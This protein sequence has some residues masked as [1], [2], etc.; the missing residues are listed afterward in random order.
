[1]EV[2]KN[3]KPVSKVVLSVLAVFIIA[4]GMGGYGYFTGFFDSNAPISSQKTESPPRLSVGSQTLV[5][6]VGAAANA[7]YKFTDA[8]VTAFNAL[9]ISTEN[10]SNMKSGF[11]YFY[12]PTQISVKEIIGSIKPVVGKRLLFIQYSP[13]D[14]KFHIYPQ[15]IFDMSQVAVIADYNTFKVDPYVPF[16]IMTDTATQYWNEALK[17]PSDSVNSTTAATALNARFTALN[18]ANGWTMVALDTSKKGSEFFV[19]IKNRIRLMSLMKP[20]A[21]FNGDDFDASTYEIAGKSFTGLYSIAWVK[22][23]PPPTTTECATTFEYGVCKVCSSTTQYMETKTDTC[24]DCPA[25]S[26]ADSSGTSCVCST[27]FEPGTGST[28]V[29]VAGVCGTN[30]SQDQYLATDTSWLATGTF[31]LKGT[32]EPAAPVFP[33]A[34]GSVTWKCLGSDSTVAT[35]DI[36]CTA[37]RAAVAVAG[38]CGT[39]NHADGLVSKPTGT[40]A[41]ATGTVNPNPA[42]NED[43]TSTYNWGCTGSGTEAT[44]TLCAGCG[45]GNH[46]DATLSKCTADAVAFKCDATTLDITHATSCASYPNPNATKTISL[47][48]DCNG[49]EQDPCVYSCNTG[50]VKSV[51]GCFTPSCSTTAPSGLGVLKIPGSPTEV[52]QAWVYENTPTEACSWKCDSSSHFFENATHDGCSC[53]AGYSLYRDDTCEKDG[54]MTGDYI[55]GEECSGAGIYF[56]TGDEA[57]AFI[58]KTCTMMLVGGSCQDR[59]STK[60]GICSTYTNSSNL[61]AICN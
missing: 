48:D 13:A 25:H 55:E 45:T 44:E 43:T 49:Y 15:G 36:E 6:S 51:N 61:V 60:S 17:G 3:S 50:Y 59:V 27:G 19:P 14:Y 46:W 2:T 42:D 56:Y 26:T 37:T 21:A 39:K 9:H 20:D 16:I 35:D 34:G 53:P 7:Y 38:T 24:K 32:A 4:A 28:C 30:Y 1:M 57:C 52:G 54:T 8:D 10:L 5:G 29:P 47:V 22:V 40:E 33:A 12:S 11:N 23:A 41:C 58:G 31:C 18:S